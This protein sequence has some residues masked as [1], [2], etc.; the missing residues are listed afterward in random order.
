MS[1]ILRVAHVLRSNASASS[2]KRRWSQLAPGFY[3]SELA[4][5]LVDGSTIYWLGGFVFLLGKV[6]LDFQPGQSL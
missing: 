6:L 2:I 4:Y 1:G 3:R 5:L